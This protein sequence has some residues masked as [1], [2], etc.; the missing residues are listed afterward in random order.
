M[1]FSEVE[2]DTPKIVFPCEYPVKVLGLASDRFQAEVLEII[3]QH[4]EVIYQDKTT[5]RPSAK[6]NYLAVTVVIEAT[7]KDQ[8]QS[9]F[10]HLMRQENVK[11]VI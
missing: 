11:L 8:L 6:G 3:G 10:Q 4:A 9:L 5:S 7:G 2:G 1:K